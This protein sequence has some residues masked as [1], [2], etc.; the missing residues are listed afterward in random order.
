MSQFLAV[1]KLA[2]EA[3]PGLRRLGRQADHPQVSVVFA[4][5]DDAV[6]IRSAARYL[7]QELHGQVYR[8]PAREG[9]GHGMWERRESHNRRA[10][11]VVNPDLAAG[12][13][14]GEPALIEKHLR[15]GTVVRDL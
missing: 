5:T 4:E 9:V 6:S 15:A 14:N 2:A 3:K 11:D 8:Y 12:F 13:L 10:S 1:A 7:G